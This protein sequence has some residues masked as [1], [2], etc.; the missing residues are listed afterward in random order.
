MPVGPLRV[1]VVEGP[2]GPRGWTT[3]N[4][5]IRACPSMLSTFPPVPK[6]VAL[7]YMQDPRHPPDTLFLVAESDYRVYEADE[8]EPWAFGDVQWHGFPVPEVPVDARPSPA[9]AQPDPPLG[10]LA[11]P[12][13]LDIEDRD[14]VP[15]TRPSPAPAHPAGPSPAPARTNVWH[16]AASS[17]AAPPLPPGEAERLRAAVAGSAVSE[18]DLAKAAAAAL[19]QAQFGGWR[20]KTPE[21]EPSQELL[22]VVG[23]VNQ[24]HRLGGRGNIVWFCWEGASSVKGRRWMP[25]HGTTFLAITVE[26]A[27]RF[28]QHLETVEPAH[29]DVILSRW[30]IAAGPENTVGAS[31]VWPSCGS[32]AQHMSGIET[33]LL[34]E[35]TWKARHVQEGFRPGP[36]K[37]WICGF[38]PSEGPEWLA[39]TVYDQPDWRTTMPPVKWCSP[40]YFWML[41]R[42]EWIDSEGEWVGP[43]WKTQRW[44]KEKERTRRRSHGPSPVPES[45]HRPSPA[46]ENRLSP[47]P[48]HAGPSPV[49]DESGKKKA[50]VDNTF[51]DDLVYDPDG[52]PRRPGFPGGYQPITRLALQLVVDDKDFDP[53]YKMDERTLRL[54]RRAQN[55]YLRRTF[56]DDEL[57]ARFP[58]TFGPSKPSGRALRHSFFLCRASLQCKKRRRTANGIGRRSS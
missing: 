16:G 55:V 18:E 22:D 4:E 38:R 8:R 53:G 20:A 10:P 2:R 9:P 31:F 25:S 43:W 27:K 23:I 13:L 57:E 41:K 15:G 47:V 40:K 42:R 14:D 37:R 5:D 11:L 46:P 28:A 6:D 19:K 32:Y 44:L 35:S 49:P 58:G 3:A 48:D 52:F 12:A 36:D 24:A 29:L 39:Q 7:P 54:R 30:L 21:C 51:W 33:N 26:G 17:S 50:W 1:L 56:T 45:H 34:R